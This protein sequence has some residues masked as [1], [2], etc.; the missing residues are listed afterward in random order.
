MIGR[1]LD[2]EGWLRAILEPAVELGVT[3]FGLTTVASSWRLEARRVPEHYVTLVV[4]EV[5]ACS[6][7]GRRLELGPDALLWLAPEVPH[8]MAPRDARRPFTFYH[9]R[10]TLCAAG[11]PLGTRRDLLHLP[12]PTALRPLME[13]LH[14]EYLHRRPFGSLCF[15]A[16]LAQFFA[17]LLRAERG[18][19]PACVGLDRVQQRHLNGFIN[20]HIRE[21][22]G[23]RELARAVQLSPDYFRQLFGA[24]YGCAPRT[25][26]MRQRMRRAA[27]L[28]L[29]SPLRISAVA[30]E[31]GY[32]DIFVFSRLFRKVWGLSPRAYRAAAAPPPV[33]F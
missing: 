8:T 5:N 16:I 10:F 20:R 6:A 26:L 19:R 33:E 11:V 17:E 15:R 24:T 9:L 7:A 14:A 32:D 27:V 28:L 29:E 18:R 12:P 31:F 30:R 22:I 21:R 13:A 23:T 2:D 3:V 25:Y 4:S 1:V